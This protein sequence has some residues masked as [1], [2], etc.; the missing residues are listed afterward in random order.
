MPIGTIACTRPLPRA[1]V[2]ATAKKIVGQG[3]ERVGHTV[4]HEVEPTAEEHR[5]DAGRDPEHQPDADRFQGREHRQPGPG[6]QPA[7][8]VAAEIVRPEQVRASSV[9]GTAR[10]C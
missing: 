1:A 5:G 6:H 9:P 8:H 10:W 7:E 3:H 4:D 2:T